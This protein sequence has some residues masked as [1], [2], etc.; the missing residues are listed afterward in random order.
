MEDLFA[1]P[2][3]AA[4][5]LAQGKSVEVREIDRER[6][7]LE[8]K[9]RADTLSAK[10]A[11]GRAEKAA[12]DAAL[13][14]AAS[15]ESAPPPR[16]RPA[17]GCVCVCAPGAPSRGSLPHPP[18]RGLPPAVDERA[19]TS[20][21]ESIRQRNKRKQGLGQATF[22]LKWDRDCGAEKAGL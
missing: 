20:D 4:S 1:A 10:A 14:Q 22:S 21:K 9:K 15:L 8:A 12:H 2:S 17:V 7:S 6:D 11:A 19:K 13:I 5:W 3:G 18:R 16:P